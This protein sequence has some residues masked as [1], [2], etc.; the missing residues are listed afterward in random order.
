MLTK[1]KILRQLGSM[2]VLSFL[3]FSLFMLILDFHVETAVLA[4]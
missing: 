1:L 2:A 4:T 3:G